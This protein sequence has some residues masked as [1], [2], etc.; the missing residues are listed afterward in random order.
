VVVA[1]QIDLRQR[2]S[3]RVIGPGSAPPSAPVE[4]ATSALANLGFA[5]HEVQRVLRDISS[6]HGGNVDWMLPPDLLR[7]AIAALT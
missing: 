1:E 3:R 6:R 2:T 5:K 7:E 4:L